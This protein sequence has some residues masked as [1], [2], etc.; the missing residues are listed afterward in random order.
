MHIIVLENQPTAARG[1]Q[2]LSLLDVC[3]GL[4]QRGH[5]ISLLYE[6]AGDLQEQ[7]QQFC[8]QTLLV[9]G[10]TIHNK[11][12]IYPLIAEVWRLKWQIPDSKDSVVYINQY[13]DSL[14][15]SA[16]ALAKQIP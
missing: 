9:K 4:S 10:Y 14:F 15:G 3:W 7:Y 16:L 2:H 1:G 8:L 11:T 6:Q 13:H 12:D 5:T